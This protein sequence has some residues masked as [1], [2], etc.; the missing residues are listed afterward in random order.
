MRRRPLRITAAGKE[1]MIN[2]ASDA[3]LKAELERR[4]TVSAVPPPKP[5]KNPDFT[6]LIQTVVNGI[7]DA[8]KNKREDDDLRGYIYEAAVEAIYGKGYWAWRRT[9]RW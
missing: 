1:M 3:E 6:E 9:Q 5:V 8:N 2:D 4:R 7:T